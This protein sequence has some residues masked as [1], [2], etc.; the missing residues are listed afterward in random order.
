MA[1]IF[2]DRE[3]DLALDDLGRSI[4]LCRIG[5]INRDPA[6]YVKLVER[7]GALNVLLL[8]KLTAKQEI[9]V[10]PAKE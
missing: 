8:K 3:L 9:K 6:T 5:N 7:M 1:D 4:A 10:L 2:K